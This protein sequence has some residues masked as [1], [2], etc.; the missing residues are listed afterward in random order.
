MKIRSNLSKLSIVHFMILLILLANFL[1]EYEEKYK[2]LRIKLIEINLISK[3]EELY[4]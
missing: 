4:I 3:D 1:L 2:N